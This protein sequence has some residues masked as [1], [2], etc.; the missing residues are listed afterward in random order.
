MAALVE[1]RFTPAEWREIDGGVLVEGIAVPYGQVAQ[2]GN[3]FRERFEVGAFGDLSA[4][5]VLVN[6]QHDRGQPLART[7]GGGLT[8]TDGRDAL[9]AAVTLPPTSEGRDTGELVKR[10]VLRGFSV[11]FVI[12]EG[13]ETWVDGLRSISRAEL[14][15]LAIVDRPAYTD[16]EVK[17]AERAKTN[18]RTPQAR[19]APHRKRV[20][21]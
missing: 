12:A 10:G 20:V 9:R 15:G 16:A 21:L 19:R 18:F 8:L 7:G 4:A 13:G 2:I 3:L 17:V 5:D 14:R 11:E 1:R 6:R